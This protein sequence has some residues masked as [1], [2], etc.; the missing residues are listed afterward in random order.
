MKNNFANARGNSMLQKLNETARKNETEKD[1]RE[2]P[3]TSLVPSKF[4][5][6]LDMGNLDS[7]ADGMKEHGFDGCIIVYDLGNGKFEIYSGHRRSYAWCVLLGNKTITAEVKPYPEDKWQR[8]NSHLLH[9]KLHRDLNI[10]FWL[11]EIKHCENLLYEDGFSGTQEQLNSEIGKRL[12][13]GNKKGA[14]AATTVYR[15]KRIGDLIPELLAFEDKGITYSSFYYATTLSKE[16]QNKLV[17]EL[18]QRTML[19]DKTITRTEM[20]KIC[21]NI[22]KQR[23]NFQPKRNRTPKNY[24]YSDLLRNSTKT[25]INFLSEKREVD[26]KEAALETIEKLRKELEIEEDRIKNL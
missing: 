8:F 1:I 3:Y 9:N 5:E 15:Y 26:D 13:L 24:T 16:E 22:K 4:N 12:G 19:H 20:A 7:L 2:I 14:D 21:N 23:S 17:D 6:D 18:A 10:N 25:M 11:T